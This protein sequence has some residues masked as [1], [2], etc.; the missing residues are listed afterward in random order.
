M[1]TPNEE[2]RNSK[3]RKQLQLHKDARV[4]IRKI[5]RALKTCVVKNNNEHL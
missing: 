5:S 2:Q 1:Q 3:V 4:V